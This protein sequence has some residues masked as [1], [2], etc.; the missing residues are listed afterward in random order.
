M[1]DITIIVAFGAGIVSFLAPCVLPLVPGFIAYLGGGAIEKKA[2]NMLTSR[3]AMLYAS[4]FFVL[5]FTAVFAV[6]G[7]VLHGALVQAGLEL[8]VLLARIGGGIVIFFGLY[9]MGLVKLSFLERSHKLSVRKKFS[10][11]ALTSFVFGAAFA[12]GW[13]PCV[14]AALGAILGLAALAPAKT[15]FLLIAYAL[16]LGV[17]FLIIG[18]FAGEIERYISRSFVWIQYLNI[19]FGGILVWLGALSFTQN[20]SVC[21]DVLWNFPF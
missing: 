21:R 1:N 4:T 2:P 17:P 12:T 13:T 10:S 7:T 19:L 6:L 20:L 14:G 8:Q 3:F 16:G 18:A 5:G 11:R 15:F 9:L